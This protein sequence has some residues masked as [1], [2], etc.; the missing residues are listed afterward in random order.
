MTARIPSY[1]LFGKRALKKRFGTFLSRTETVRIQSGAEPIH[2]LRVASRRFHAAAQLFA[3]SVS[4]GTLADC[5]KQIRRIR[6]SSGAVRDGDV[7]IASVSALLKKRIPRRYRPGL[8]RLLLRLSQQREKRMRRASAALDAFDKSE[9]S[10]K[11][12]QALTARPPARSA[13]RPL[14]V[15]RRAAREISL[16]LEQLKRCEQYVHQPTAVTELHTM[17]IEAKRLRYV[18]E[19][20][21]PL[22]GGKLKPF[23][24]TVQSMQE[25]LGAMHDCDVWIE[26]LPLFLERERLRTAKY[27]GDSSSFYRI[28]RGI[29]F[30]AD[31][32]RAQRLKHY[33]SFV[34]IWMSA[35]R[36]SLWNRLMTTIT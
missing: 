4:P 33:R 29:V 35:T 32:V 31:H 3:D 26:T 24:Q 1:R 9:M 6:K 2:D 21:S 30:F 8:E 34:R 25:S 15:R 27:F 36:R 11:M 12:K 17:R 10:Q 5:E 28:E 14:S 18:M 20:F 23:I 16:R 7:Q 19:I 13:L 22:Y